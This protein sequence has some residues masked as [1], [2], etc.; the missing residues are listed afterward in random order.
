[1]KIIPEIKKV[2]YDSFTVEVPEDKLIIYKVNDSDYSIQA[3]TYNGQESLGS[4]KV[5]LKYVG[6]GNDIIVDVCK[7]GK[8][9]RPYGAFYGYNYA[10]GHAEMK[11]GL[12]KESFN[13][14]TQIVQEQIN[15]YYKEKD[16]GIDEN[17][18]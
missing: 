14:K 15:D 7:D 1:M 5:I 12:D 8:A 17:N 10:I 4:E 16:S 9:Y 18:N 2:V 11:I 6:R 3:F 13:R